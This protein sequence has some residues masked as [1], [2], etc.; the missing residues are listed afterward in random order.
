MVGVLGGFTTFS[1]FSVGTV[2]L[3]QNGRP[4]AASL[5][6]MGSVGFCLLGTLLGLLLAGAM[7]EQRPD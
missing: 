4:L 1:S 7:V 2:N 5:Y 3:F 6:I